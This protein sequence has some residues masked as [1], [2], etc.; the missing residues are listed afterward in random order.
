MRCGERGGLIDLYN[1]LQRN[2]VDVLIGTQMVAKG[3]DLPGVTLVGV[4]SADMSLSIPDFRAGE[5]TFQLLTQVAGRAG[6]GSKKGRVLVQTL[7]PENTVIKHA[8]RQD[9][10]GFLKRE[11]KLRSQLGYP[12]FSKL[13]NIKFTGK[14]NSQTSGAAGTVRSIASKLLQKFPI[15]S[16]EILGPSESPIG[17]I[18]NKY[19][20]QL[21]LKSESQKD[22][23]KF[24]RGLQ[25]AL[26]LVQLPAGV[27]ITF[28]VDPV[29]F[30]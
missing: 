19:R 5:R 7:K 27:R 3:H 24:A 1:K 17:K 18:K 20:W 8:A 6:R 16:V 26:R 13:I 29:S 11:L 2:E 23:H 15:E 28:D 10:A 9:S 4:I 30:S 22:L 14:T 21:L 12:P 25:K